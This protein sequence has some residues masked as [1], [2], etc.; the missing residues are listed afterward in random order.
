MLTVEDIER[1]LSHVPRL[2]EALAVLV[3]DGLVSRIGDLVGVSRAAVR[4]EQL[5][6]S[7]RL[8]KRPPKA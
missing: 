6:T 2:R 7:K 8:A 4:A 3:S 5:T 1:R